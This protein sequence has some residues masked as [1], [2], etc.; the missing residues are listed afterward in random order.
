[1]LICKELH[2]HDTY[3][4]TGKGLPVV[5]DAFLH[6]PSIAADKAWVDAGSPKWRDTSNTSNWMC[7][8]LMTQNSVYCI[9]I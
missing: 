8:M 5:A 2:A 6:Y 4:V 1:M 7:Q 3:Y 9:G